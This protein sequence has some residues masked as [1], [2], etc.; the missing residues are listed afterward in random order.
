MN[1]R[2][3]SDNMLSCGTGITI[4]QGRGI[5]VLNLDLRNSPEF[6]AL[7]NEV[8]HLSKLIGIVIKEDPEILTKYDNV[9][10]A[11]DEYCLFR[12]LVINNDKNKI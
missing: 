8:E 5:G 4:T 1:S 2:M 7:K 3:N 11:F 9:R 6:M 12:D 10:K